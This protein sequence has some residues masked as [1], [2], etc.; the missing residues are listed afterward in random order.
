MT[1]LNER[2]YYLSALSASLALALSSS[3]FARIGETLEQAEQRYGKPTF[4]QGDYY[5]YK[6]APFELI[7]H[8]FDG[9]ADS[10]KYKKIET[11]GKSV[12]L[13]QREIN[14]LLDINSGGDNGLRSGMIRTIPNNGPR[15]AQAYMR[16]TLSKQTSS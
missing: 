14:A 15:T 13:S 5:I 1:K 10:I 6:K 8:F 9:K 4:E 12:R 16:L 7:L 3:C 2:W 11:K